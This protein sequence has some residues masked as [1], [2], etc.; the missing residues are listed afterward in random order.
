MMMHPFSKGALPFPSITKAFLNI[1]IGLIRLK[2]SIDD[3]TV[4]LC[5]MIHIA[6]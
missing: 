6:G 5:Q 3:H 1:L 2:L 4:R